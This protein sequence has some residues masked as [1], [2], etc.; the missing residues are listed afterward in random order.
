ME[1]VVLQ[2]PERLH[3]HGV[4]ELF[5]GLASCGEASVVVLA[6]EPEKF[7]LGMDIE[8]W[9]HS[10]ISA[11]HARL[12]KFADLLA[13]LAACPRPTL[14]VIDGPALAGGLGL[15]AVCDYVLASDRARFGL[16]EA[17]SGLAPAIIRPVLEARLTPAQ[18]RTLLFTGYSRDASEAARLGLVDEVA[19][20]GELAS[21]RKR[22]IRQLGRARTKTVLAVRRWQTGLADALRAGVEETTAALHD[23]AVRAALAEEVPWAHS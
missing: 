12:G 23:P 10:D 18:L 16:P 5:R 20:V 3:A 6:G 13:A 1:P 22:A 19:L 14:A 8:E 2:V 21:A 9:T 11:T 15:A 7:C 17:L 4:A